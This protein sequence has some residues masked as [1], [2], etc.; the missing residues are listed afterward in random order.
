MSVTL[1]PTRGAFRGELSVPGDKSVSHRSLLIPALARGT[2]RV[3]GVLESEDVGRS[4]DLVRAL[5]ATVEQKGGEWFVTGAPPREPEDIVDCGNSGTTMRLGCG[6]LAHAPGLRVLTGDASLRRRPMAR[7]LGPLSSMG[8]DGSAR[9]GGRL[10]PI[11]LQ[12]GI[13][14]PLDMELPVASAQVKSAILLAARDVGC[15][16]REPGASRDHTERLLE[17][18]GARIRS[19]RGWVDLEPGPWEAADI[20]V[21]GD[22]SSAAFWLAAAAIVPGSALLLRDVGVNPTRDGVL[23]A[24]AKMGVDIQRENERDTTEPIADLLVRHGD[25]QGIRIDGGL[26]LSCLDEIPILAVVAACAAGETVIADAAELRVKESDRIARVVEGLRAFG[27]EVEERPDGM[28]IQGGR[29]SGHRPRIDARGDH[30]LAMA[31]SIAGL[32][33]PEGV[34][35]VHAESVRTSYPAFFEHLAALQEAR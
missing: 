23:R 34:E 6:V 35:L 27:V 29:F 24:L 15:S 26:A 19:G 33:H 31:F 8:L 3:R 16:L 9:Q 13:T 28:V 11:V 18:M 5:G 12:G 10:A 21:P 2:S 22:L 20:E 14:D 7:I 4:R 17:A 30:R 32:L 25:L 1:A